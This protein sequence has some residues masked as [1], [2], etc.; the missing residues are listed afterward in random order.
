MMF[1]IIKRIKLWDMFHLICGGSLIYS[2]LWVS[3]ANTELNDR[4]EERCGPADHNLDSWSCYCKDGDDWIFEYKDDYK[5]TG[6]ITR[7]R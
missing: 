6:T 3:C 7:D 5:D 2:V 4:C 1:D